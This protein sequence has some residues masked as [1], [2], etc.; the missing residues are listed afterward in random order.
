MFVDIFSPSGFL[1]ILDALLPLF[2]YGRHSRAARCSE[3]SAGCLCHWALSPG[4]AFLSAHFHLKPVQNLPIPSNSSSSSLGVTATR[5][6]L[7]QMR[8]LRLTDE[9]WV[10]EE[11]SKSWSGS[12]RD[13]N[14]AIALDPHRLS[15]P[16]LPAVYLPRIPS[17]CCN[18]ERLPDSPIHHNNF[19]L[20][21]SIPLRAQK[22]SRRTPVSFDRAQLPADV[23]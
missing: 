7:I 12:P 8:R 21:W 22:A 19:L 20:T 4:S 15:T 6:Y 18:Q 13:L 17:A 5:Q 1:E 16:D 2:L 23:P 9:S 10:A 11:K 14:C 3:L